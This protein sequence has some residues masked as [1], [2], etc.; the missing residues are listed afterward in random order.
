M[1]R[2]LGLVLVLVLAA[3]AVGA[4]LLTVQSRKESPG[5]NGV[6]QVESQ[7]ASSAAGTSFQAA[8]QV[9][10]GWYA[11]NGT[12]AGATLPPGSGLVVARA[13]ASG[14]CLQATVGTAVEHELGPG[15][16]PQPGAC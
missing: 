13:D 12:Y 2:S 11:S 1:T 8:A 4:Y 6:A 5:A 7:A 14:Y 3:L 16:A 9:L 10:Q 15:G